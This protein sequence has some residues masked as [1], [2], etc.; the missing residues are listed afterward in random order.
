MVRGYFIALEGIDGAGTTTQARRLAGRL[1]R[2]G[3]TV[4]L[5]REPSAGPVGRLIDRLITTCPTDQ[6]ST[7]EFHKTLA[8]LFA[9]DRL[10]HLTRE[11]L[12]A[13]SESRVVITDRYVL[14]SWAYQSVRVEESWVREINR[15]APMAD[16]TLVLDA[17]VDVCMERVGRRKCRLQVFE[18]A[19]FLRRVR[20][21]YRS[22]A[23]QCARRHN[24]VLVDAASSIDGVEAAV[25]S[26]VQS[27][28]EGRRT[29]G[30]GRPRGRS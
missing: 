15:H 30:P 16:L 18:H 1:R 26:L 25:W 14:S 3:R 10:D 7:A 29:K 28:L 6:E 11:I 24:V 9:A 23:R 27:A 4:L 2:T 12:P 17:P 8:L 20:A 21:R 13:L 5:T 19:A 22:I